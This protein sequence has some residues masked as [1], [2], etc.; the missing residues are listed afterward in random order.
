MFVCNTD[1]GVNASQFNVSCIFHRV[2]A[3][4]VSGDVLLSGLAAQ[5][6]G[7]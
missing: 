4:T 3:L 2:Y 1:K 5:A 7:K 6:K